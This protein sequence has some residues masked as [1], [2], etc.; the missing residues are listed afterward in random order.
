MKSGRF[1]S[2]NSDL[3]ATVI[4]EFSLIAKAVATILI[5]FGLCLPRFCDL[6]AN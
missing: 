3:A 6:Y 5:H 1:K 2:R 4:T